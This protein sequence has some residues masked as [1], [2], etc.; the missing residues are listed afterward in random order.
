MARRLRGAPPFSATAVR[1]G[2]VW[3]IAIEGVGSTQAQSTEEA[4]DRAARLIE[5]MT[6][7][8][9]ARVEIEFVW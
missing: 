8:K 7:E 5:T 9:G 1:E 2:A 3:I 6:D 4:Y